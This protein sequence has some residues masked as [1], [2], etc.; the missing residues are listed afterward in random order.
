MACEAT[1]I[2]HIQGEDHKSKF[3]SVFEAIERQG[4]N[5]KMAFGGI[6]FRYNGQGVG[7]ETFAETNL[8]YPDVVYL[9]APWRYGDLVA[10]RQNVLHELGHILDYRTRGNPD[11]VYNTAFAT[12]NS[13]NVWI[14][15]VGD[16]ASGKA[17]GNTELPEEN[18]ADYFYFW[19]DPDI[20]IRRELAGDFYEDANVYAN[21]GT[22][23][24]LEDQATISV[25]SPGFLGWAEQAY[26]YSLV[27]IALF[28][29][30]Q[31]LY[32]R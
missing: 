5:F 21:G 10:T 2:W 28:A 31:V 12:E 8:P 29:L 3:Q 20:G 22:V 1:D 9:Q 15:A 14:P 18:V 6:E 32:P 16:V 25:T 24:V 4:M 17:L 30:W 27:K 19:A 11:G 26:P 13:E 7:T 23:D